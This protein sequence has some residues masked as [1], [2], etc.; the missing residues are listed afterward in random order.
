MREMHRWGD[1]E[2]AP[3][4]V[5]ALLKS[6]RRPRALDARTRARSRRRIRGLAALP[7]AGG[8]LFWAQHVAL[9][10]VLGAAVI[11]TT[12]V[13]PKIFAV[14]NSA[15]QQE[16]TKAPVRDVLRVPAQSVAPAMTDVP[17][18]E[19]LAPPPGNDRRLRPRADNEQH[20]LALEAKRLEQ[21]RAL[22]SGDPNRALVALQ[23]QQQEF[24]H[25]TL[26]IERELLEVDA[27]VR[28]GRRSEAGARARTL[29]AT[30]PGSLYEE[31]LKRLLDSDR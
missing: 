16:P 12:T 1:D 14:H 4:E 25:G 17:Q 5:I 6:A 24:P 22:L 23:R 31:R 26:E 3:P 20:D 19:P 21:A 8:A 18:S 30:A 29:R 27:L 13:A 10:A 11:A 28:L 15:L 2:D 9:G 7:A